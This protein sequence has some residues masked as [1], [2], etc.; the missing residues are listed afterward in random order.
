MEHCIAVRVCRLDLA[1]PLPTPQAGDGICIM[2]GP[3][4]VYEE[5]RHPWLKDES[6]WIRSF[7]GTDIPM[8]GVCLG[9]QLLADA[10]GSKVYAN[11]VKEIG[12]MPV[13]WSEQARS[14]F[15]GLETSLQVLHWHGDTFDLPGGGLLLASS[16]HCLNQAF[17][18]ENAL[19]LQFHLEAGITECGRLIENCSDELAYE[20]PTVHDASRLRHDSEIFSGAAFESMRGLLN[21]HF[22]GITVNR[23]INHK[24][25]RLCDS[26]KGLET[27]PHDA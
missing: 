20:T 1:D 5:D 18:Y 7:L 17:L 2:G 9:A 22:G 25:L 8:L 4:N 24:D 27:G 15:P 6:A 16:A 11:R 19:G 10:L 26:Y 3:M 14:L 13:R 12:W 21:A 23:R